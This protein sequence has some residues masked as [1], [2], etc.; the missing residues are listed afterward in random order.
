[1]SS[2]LSG[3][4]SLPTFSPN[5]EILLAIFLLHLNKVRHLLPA[6]P[7]PRRPEIQQQ[8]FSL[9]VGNF[10]HSAVDKLQIRVRDRRN[11]RW[12]IRALGAGLIIRTAARRIRAAASAASA[13]TR[14]LTASR[15]RIKATKYFLNYFHNLSCTLSPYF[16]RASAF[17]ELSSDFCILASDFFYLPNIFQSHDDKRRKYQHPKH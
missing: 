17:R 2:M 11:Q 6:R 7:A 8:N 16:V 9:T 10:C 14:K 12:I 1:M 15:A 5:L 13:A 4:A 3:P